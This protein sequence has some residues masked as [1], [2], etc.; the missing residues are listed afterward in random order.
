MGGHIARSEVDVVKQI[1]A[2]PYRCDDQGNLQVLLVTSRETGRWVIPKGWPMKGRSDCKAASKE[3]NE[4]A[5]V[6]GSV[7][8][9]PIGV[10]EYFKRVREGF[11]LIEVTVFPLRVD[12]QL[13]KWPE[14]TE[15]KRRWFSIEEA[16]RTVMEPGLQSLLGS[17]CCP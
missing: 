10:Y 4:E 7:G 15:R 5:G 14:M 8:R 12:E 1:G 17:L 9:K 16:Q 3:A 6:K 11:E 13:A 2:I